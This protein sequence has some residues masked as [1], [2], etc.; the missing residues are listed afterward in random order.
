MSLL[1][2][3][4]SAF[5]A[6]LVTA[7]LVHAQ[8]TGATLQGT[9]T[10]EQSALMPGASVTITNTETGWTRSVVTDERGW[11]RATALPPGEYELRAELQG[12]ATYVRKGLTLTTGQ[13]ATVNLS[14]KL[15]TV[16][17]TVTVTADAPLVETT[18][19][20]LG[21]TVSRS[22]LDSLPL[23]GR[24]FAGLTRLSAGIT[25]VGGGGVTASGQTD[26]SNSY[27]VDGVSNDQVV[28]AGQ[29][30]GFSLEAVR[31][32]AVMANQ[33]TAEFGQASGAVVSVIT[34]SGTNDLR[35]R[36]FVFH[37]DDA[38]DAQDPFSKAQGSGKAPFSQQRYGAFVG[39]P[40]VRDKLH[41]FGT[42][43][44]ERQR[45][46]TVITSALVPV[47]ERE[48]PN[49]SDGHQAF[50]K[51]DQRL[52]TAQSLSLRYRADKDSSN[53]NSIGGLN[54]R[55]RG[56]NTES[57][58]Q[59]IVAN[60]TYVISSRALNELRVQFGRHSTWTNTEGWSTDGMPEISRPSIRLGKAYNQPQGRNEN[61]TQIINN[62][63]Y[64]LS[65]HE[66]KGGIDVSIIRA[67]TFFPRNRDGTFT[68]TTDR[69]FDPNDLTT[70]PTQ[71]TQSVADPWVDLDEEI[72]AFFAQ[73][74]WRARTN[75]TLNFG[76]RYDR[77]TAFSTINGVP[78]D[79]NNVAPR[80]GFVWDPTGSGRTAVRGGVGLYVD[81]VFLNPPLNVVLAQ[82][83]R[84]IT[85]VNPGYPDPF[86]R[87]SV[88]TGAPS[89]SVASTNMRTPENR[90]VSLGVKR[91]L[92]SGFAVSA[93]G[94]YSRGYNQFNNRDLNPLDPTTGLR[95]NP[96]YVRITQYETEGHAWYSALLMSVERRAGRGPAFGASYTFAK[97]IR[98]V[99]GFLFLAQDQLNPAAEKAL[100][101]NHRAHQLVAHL[102]WL[103]PAGV[104][105][106]GL[107]QARSGQ[108]WNVTTGRDNNGDT[109]QNDRPDLAVPGGDPRSVSTYFA[110]FT[111]RVGNL[112]RNA[113]IGD[114]FY[115]L[116]AR[117]SKFQQIQRFRLEAFIE[118]FNLLNHVNVQSPTSNLRSASFGRSTQIQGA[119]RQVELGFR[120][121][122]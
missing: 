44:G 105:V 112:G 118:A 110:N 22:E 68:F 40:L 88:G 66:F 54:S 43:E 47:N 102:T 116:D 59:D 19:N 111:G 27:M 93:D 18:R 15:A 122:F 79:T 90:S 49:P 65:T 70:Y 82:R 17:E 51:T 26:R 84:D 119:M 7:P 71:F 99:E 108:P 21:T 3:F 62:L 83:A 4:S 89:I 23:I 104:Q 36:A 64:T 77:E 52:N 97:A 76:I 58:V 78:D 2:W 96:A 80:F 35:G 11:Y 9:V 30:G 6:M 42:Y 5:A 100:A 75:L 114:S 31:E 14:L 117:V 109:E 101:T 95:P 45:E 13:E 56:T 33:F 67:P 25:G 55:E 48:T 81:Q 113:N 60:H 63:T 92:F 34:R 61:R 50:V 94:V 20:A 53:G 115:T 73:D 121:D 41:Y 46:T 74:S 103:L 72:Y 12:F 86:T 39:G 85:I 98:D 24:D 32:F 1:S 10:D 37:R 91:E 29:R 107:F 28:T 8:T 69:P 57:L 16:A 87:G 106:A 120:V 38:L